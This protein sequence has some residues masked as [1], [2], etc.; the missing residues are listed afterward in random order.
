MLKTVKSH[1]KKPRGLIGRITGK[2]MAMENKT[3]NEWTIRQLKI[4]SGD[5]ILEVGYGPGY[6]IDYI[7]D[8][9]PEVHVDGIDVS[10]TMKDQATHR[11]DSEIEEGHVQ[12]AA[13]DV[14]QA[15][16]KQNYYHKVF[17]VNNYT[18]WE[19][20]KT[21]LRNLYNTLVPG[22]KIAITMQPRQE[23]ANSNKTRTFA[24][25]IREDLKTCGYRRIKVQFKKIPPELAVCV[26]AVK[27]G[28]RPR[29]TNFHP[30]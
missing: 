11:L 7:T 4:H 2:I 18:L 19:E 24:K 26:T 13:E 8:H 9:Y 25:E 12:L 20:K 1:F 17:T 14:S 16:F 23:D 27:P 30:S 29:Q 28:K 21:G 10:K 6:S 15:E 5:R 22:G 3:L